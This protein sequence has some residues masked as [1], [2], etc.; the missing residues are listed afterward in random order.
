DEAVL[1]LVATPPEARRDDAL[2]VAAARLPVRAQERLFRLLAA[3]GQLRE[4]ADLSLPPARRCRFVLPDAH[5]RGSVSGVLGPLPAVSASGGVYPRCWKDHGDT[6]RGS[7][8]SLEE[9]DRRTV[10]VQRHDGFLPVRQTARVRAGLRRLGLA[11]P[12]LRPHLL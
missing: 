5:G 11:L 8:R 4:V 9:L 3:V 12:H 6:P 7:P 10:L 2:V 1:A